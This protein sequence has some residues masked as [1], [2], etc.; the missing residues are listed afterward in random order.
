MSRDPLQRRCLPRLAAP[1]LS[2]QEE[3][4]TSVIKAHVPGT[5]ATFLALFRRFVTAT[6][7]THA[8]V[9]PTGFGVFARAVSQPVRWQRLAP[10]CGC[11]A[12]QCVP[13]KA[14]PRAARSPELLHIRPPADCVEAHRSPQDSAGRTVPLE[15]AARR[16]AVLTASQRRVYEERA[17]AEHAQAATELCRKVS[18]GPMRRIAASARLPVVRGRCSC[19]A[20]RRSLPPAVHSLL[21]HAC[22]ESLLRS[23]G[24]QG[25]RRRD[26]PERVRP[27]GLVNAVGLQRQTCARPS[28]SPPRQRSEG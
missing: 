8:P 19:A 27:S 28:R 24:C 15:E 2:S 13:T 11:S 25:P 23:D 14:R 12:P 22:S 18:Q 4:S 10:S 21:A 1:L 17:R 9:K 3:G 6:A 20:S 26:R 16:W 5:R 7:A